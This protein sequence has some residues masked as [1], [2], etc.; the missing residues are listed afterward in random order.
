MFRLLQREMNIDANENMPIQAILAQSTTPEFIRTV[1][2]ATG[3]NHINLP[4]VTCAEAFLHL[5][6]YFYC[7]RFVSKMTWNDFR[8]VV[9]ICSSLKLAKTF[10]DL[11]RKADFAKTKIT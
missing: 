2:N 4:S 3:P 9:E 6:E 5:L 1:C 7:D 8:L 10:A 11:Q